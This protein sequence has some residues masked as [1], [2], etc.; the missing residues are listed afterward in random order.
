[1]NPSQLLIVI[2]NIHYKIGA[3]CQNLVKLTCLTMIGIWSVSRLSTK[4]DPI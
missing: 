4:L 3:E 1:M 2:Q